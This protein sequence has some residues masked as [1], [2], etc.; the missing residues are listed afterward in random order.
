MPEHVLVN[1]D[2]LEILISD[3]A[4]NVLRTMIVQLTGLVP[5]I[6]VLTLVKEH[7]EL[8]QYARWHIII[9]CAYVLTDTKETP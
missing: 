3:V 4:L 2:I 6:N 8:M 5:I 7:A 1:L 9:L